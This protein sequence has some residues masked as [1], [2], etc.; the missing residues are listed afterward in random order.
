MGNII[1][2]FCCTKQNE[3][4]HNSES[5][6]HDSPLELRDSKKEK[7]IK[8]KDIKLGLKSETKLDS[9]RSN[10]NNLILNEQKKVKSILI[11]TDDHH[12]RSVLFEDA[13]DNDIVEKLSGHY[14]VDNEENPSK[15]GFAMKDFETRKQREIK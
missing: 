3:A 11:G 1:C 8:N 14:E 10:I 12:P 13:K 6:Q 7:L 5:L 15:T 2:C 4:T 9:V